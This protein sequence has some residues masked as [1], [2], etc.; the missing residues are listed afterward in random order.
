VADITIH[1]C[2][3]RIVRH[4]GWSWGP[5][6]KKLIQIALRAL[7]AILAHELSMFCGKQDE[8]ESVAYLNITIP[9]RLEDLTELANQDLLDDSFEH[10]TEFTLSGQRITSAVRAALLTRQLPFT[11]HSPEFTPSGQKRIRSAARSELVTQQPPFTPDEPE[12]RSSHVSQKEHSTSPAHVSVSVFDVL[13]SWQEQGVLQQR[14]A[15]F[16]LRALEAWHH[17]IVETSANA[18]LPTAVELDAIPLL[19]KELS[20]VL[21]ARVRT[22]EAI[23]RRRLIVLVELMARLKIVHCSPAILSNLED[24]LPLGVLETPEQ[25]QIA[26]DASAENIV[27][28]LD[29]TSELPIENQAQEDHVFKPTTVATTAQHA[30]HPLPYSLLHPAKNVIRHDALALP[31]LL[32]GP[33]SEIGYLK[34]LAAALD[35]ANSLA[36]APLFATALAYKVLASPQRGWRRQSC[37]V[38]TASIFAGLET[39]AP[40]PALI[41]F[42]RILS[43]HVSP[44]ESIL[45]GTL[46]A[47][48]DQAQP[49][50]LL[51]SSVEGINGFLLLDVEGCF[52]LQWAA[53]LSELRPTLIQLDSSLVLIPENCAEPALLRWMTE[54]GFRFVTDARPTRGEELRCVRRAPRHRWWTNDEITSD[55]LIARAG[56]SMTS[57]FE[58]AIALWQSLAI[59]RP[60]IPL[61]N[62]S[63]LES[64]LTMAAAVALGTIAWE[65]WRETETTAPHV[66]LDRFSD[67]DARVEYTTDSVVVSLPFGK[68][69]LDLQRRA[70]LHDVD[71]VPW[72]D[73]RKLTFKSA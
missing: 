63:Q 36:A 12:A 69:F 65:L 45:T 53:D 73:G 62:D 33:L 8:D 18:T 31:F 22:R 23:L 64:H 52:P 72:F 58:D 4:G 21:G 15:M 6:P 14:L 50:L 26:N 2:S 71:D 48:H 13:R 17:R 34:T 56:S 27:S 46:I 25:N 54:E 70:L 41:D 37:S 32:L 29:S 55:S 39:P 47:G 10:S 57:S 30:Q 19:I 42:A 44:L 7:P 35:A 3:L 49:L 51:S 68:R 24:F 40:E 9:V 66:A 11:P 5:A 20:Q 59:E 28:S 67:L 1:R 38:S 43:D 16:S 60:A 61:A